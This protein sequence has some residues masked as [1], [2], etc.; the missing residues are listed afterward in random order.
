M[1]SANGHVEMVQLL[2][3]RG[4]VS[5]WGLPTYLPAYPTAPWA[6][7]HTH[8]RSLQNPDLPNF[9]KNTPLHWAC[10][11][12]HTAVVEALVKAGASPSALNA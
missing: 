5:T 3:D 7:L 8:R 12:G 6:N 11:N 10:L 1:A 2:L 4:A 9:Q